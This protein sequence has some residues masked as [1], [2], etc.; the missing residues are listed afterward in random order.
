MSPRPLTL[1]ILSSIDYLRKKIR[2]ERRLRYEKFMAAIRTLQC[3]L[4]FWK[5]KLRRDALRRA[6]HF[7][8]ATNFIRRWIHGKYAIDAARREVERRRVSVLG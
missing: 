1:R 8:N 3:K 7:I 6:M 4:R 2:D 5:L